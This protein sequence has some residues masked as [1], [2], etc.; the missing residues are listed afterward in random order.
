MIYNI[1]VNIVAT[2]IGSYFLFSILEYDNKYSC[3]YWLWKIDKTKAQLNQ[4]VKTRV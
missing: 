4:I 3:L 1:F 2:I